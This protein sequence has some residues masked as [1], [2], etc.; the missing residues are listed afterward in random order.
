MKTHRLAAMLGAPLLAGAIVAA[1]ANAPPAPA[2]PTV[3][4]NTSSYWRMFL[5]HRKALVWV[6]DELREKCLKKDTSDYPTKGICTPPPPVNWAAADFDDGAWLRERGPLFRVSEKYA[7]WVYPSMALICLRGRFVVAD[8]KSVGDMTL[9]L[10]YRGGVV[11]YINGREVARG[12]LPDKEGKGL[13]ALAEDYPPETNMTTDGKPL[14]EEHRKDPQN[15]EHLEKR[16]RRLA[17]VTIPANHLRQ[18]TNV[19]A[20]EIHRS[21]LPR[22]AEKFRTIFGSLAWTPIGLVNVELK[23]TGAGVS[24][25]IARPAGV[26]VWAQTPSQRL[27]DGDYCTPEDRALGV[28]RVLGARNGAFPGQIVVSS[29]QAI[30]GLKAECSDLTG[31]DTIPAKAIQVRFPVQD[32]LGGG[33]RIYDQNHEKTFDTLEDTAPSELPVP[34]GADGTIQPVWLTV[35]VPRDAKPGEYKGTVTVAVEGTAP[36]QMPLEVSV[37]DWT[38]PDPKD[39]QTE[40]GL[41]ES[42]ESVALKYGVELWSEKHWQLLDR[43]FS[44]MALVGAD[45]VHILLQRRLHFGNSQSMVRWIKKNDGGYTHDF[46]IVERYLDLAI[47]HL[48][49][50]AVVCVVAWD[51]A[52]GLRPPGRQRAER[53]VRFTVL[54]PKTGK[55]EDAEGPRFG[56]PESR[57]FWK[58]VFDGLRKIMAA[59]GLEQAMMHG[60]LGDAVPSKEAWDDL[61]AVAPGVRWVCQ[62]HPGPERVLHGVPKDQYLGCQAHVYIGLNVPNPDG[63]DKRA[64]GWQA[65]HRMA[66]FPRD[67]WHHTCPAHWRVL[68]E[69]HL[70]KGFLGIARS[71]AD[72]FEIPRE[73]LKR[74]GYTEFGGL[75]LCNRYPENNWAQTSVTV[76]SARWMTAG[77]DGPLSTMR[78]E[79]CRT[80]AQECEA[81]IFI[82]RAL[83]DAEKRARLGDDLAKR[84]QELLDERQRA[85]GIAL[86]ETFWSF[87]GWRW[88][89]TTGELYRLA[90]EAAKKLGG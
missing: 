90:A 19:L 50:P 27:Y 41:V 12:H 82:E 45:H 53:G 77:K 54:D 70:T 57:E 42:P 88:E 18:G 17:N 79:L 63:P 11:V 23:A 25:S 26:Q 4:L 47:E 5:T 44:L 60:I 21:A 20:I 36:V 40:V 29:S 48:G 67:L 81:R 35:N 13:E 72:W 38:L 74:E 6:G 62:N 52:D 7:E 9:S 46:G 78:L 56:T 24:P 37:A 66:G 86:D 80:G 49:K 55:L 34:K 84:C 43:V 61:S 75:T 15:A 3:V 87:S 71:G 33:M 73:V 64:Y 1:A 51:F 76:A 69:K 28:V 83:V 58:P 32:G 68:L 22:D 2:G 65:P 59:R 16:V 8:P 31:P 10:A 30:L 89:E 14:L 85:I 39:F